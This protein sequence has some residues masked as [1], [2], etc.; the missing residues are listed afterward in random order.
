MKDQDTMKAELFS[1]GVSNIRVSLKDHDNTTFLM[2]WN[3]KGAR[4]H[5]WLDRVTRRINSGVGRKTPTL[6]KNPPDD[7]AATDPGYYRTRYLDARKHEPL[8]RRIENYADAAGLFDG[9]VANAE[10]KERRRLAE[11]KEAARQT[12][13]MAAGPQL[14]DACRDALRFVEQHTKTACENDAPR[15][16]RERLIIKLRDAIRA[17]G[18]TP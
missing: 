3:E 13:I 10:A 1:L 18:E 16:G 5:L 8:L 7:L 14:L 17:A 6:Y 4:L 15:D 9:A 11:A 12:H 2:S